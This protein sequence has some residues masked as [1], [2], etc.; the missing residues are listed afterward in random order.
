MAVINGSATIIYEETIAAPGAVETYNIPFYLS[1][2]AGALSAPSAITATVSF[3]PIGVSP[4]MCRTSSAASSTATINVA[5]ITPCA[6]TITFGQL[7]D[8]VF[9]S[10]AVTLS[11]TASSSLPVTY[12]ST[13]TG[14]C[15]IANNIVTL[16]AGGT[17]SITASQP[18][19]SYFAAAPGVVQGFTIT[20]AAQ[21]ITFVTPAGIPLSFGPTALEITASSGLAVSLTSTTLAVCSVSG[22]NVIPLTLG[23]CSV[24]ADQAGNAS[25]SAAPA[26]TRRFSVINGLP[27]IS[28][29]AIPA[30]I[31]GTPPF[32]ISAKASTGLP[33]GFAS[34]TPSR[35]Q[36]RG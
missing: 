8:V 2:A 3:A 34:T 36:N 26:V 19:N 11:G 30:Q 13:T 32:P 23:T 15:T 18:G 20:P 31:L 25:Y 5:T 27:A 28:F 21:T 29:A 1:A 33:V 12:T 10:G 22:N 7:S 4:P 6:S 16:K 17:C 9:G 35:L 24:T 14:I